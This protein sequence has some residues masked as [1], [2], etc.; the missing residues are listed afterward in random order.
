M[1]SIAKKIRGIFL[2]LAVLIVGIASLSGCDFFGPKE[3]TKNVELKVMSFNIRVQT[4]DDKGEKN[5]SKRCAP[6][7]EYLKASEAD[8]ICL[9]E[10]TKTQADNLTD[11]LDG[12]YNLVFYERE[13]SG[14][15]EGL[16]I[17]YTDD[18]T[19]KAQDRFWL[20]ETPDE[21]S[22]GWGANYYRICV[23]LLL[24][25][26]ETGVYMD[27]YNVHL[28]HQV[29][30]A[31]E[32]GLQL[33]LQKSR[34]KGYPTVLAGD[35]NTTKESDCIKNISSEMTN[36]QEEAYYESD[37][38]ITYH[39]WGTPIEELNSKSAIDFCFVSRD[40]LP[41]EFDILQETRGEDAYYSDH[42]AITSLLRFTYTVTTK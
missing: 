35:F 7:V 12:A 9:Q 13:N 31:R 2:F 37:E 22:K 27:V 33:I 23:N 6:V 17:C 36:C 40:I 16:A 20:S 24:Q 21:M 8:V 15:A 34:A 10:V 4:A 5:W 1:K 14:N 11:G 41:L 32:N 42:Y 30:L 29:E 38:G 39:N 19:L 28:D 25:H 18:F 3:K 26:N